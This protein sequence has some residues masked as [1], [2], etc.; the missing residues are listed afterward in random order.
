MLV[1]RQR[2]P[3]VFP[4]LANALDVAH[5][6]SFRARVVKGSS[7]RECPHLDRV[8]RPRFGAS[9]GWIVRYARAGAWSAS[10]RP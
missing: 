8:K 7:Q 1:P 4:T 6:S 2:V 10:E 3:I 5:G 9:G